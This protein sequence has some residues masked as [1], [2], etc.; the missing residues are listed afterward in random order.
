MGP[1]AG[2][3]RPQFRL[4]QGAR[5]W[6]LSLVVFLEA[7]LQKLKLILLLVDTS[8]PSPLARYEHIKPNK[9]TK[10]P[11]SNR[12]SAPSSSAAASRPQPTGE[13]DLSALAAK[14]AEMK[15]T[16]EGQRAAPAENQWF[17]GG[18]GREDPGSGPPS[19]SAGGRGPQSPWMG[20]PVGELRG[21]MLNR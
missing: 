7:I 11:A 19:A 20:G 4:N 13:S 8:S 21:G 15:V 16:A 9:V 5:L 10:D 6:F 12:G 1:L 17:S 18:R 2:A 3:R 14:V